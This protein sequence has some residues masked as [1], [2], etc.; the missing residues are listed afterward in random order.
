V[1]R[2]IYITLQ[3]STTTSKT[4]NQGKGNEL[5]HCH[6]TLLIKKKKL[7]N[8]DID[9]IQMKVADQSINECS[10]NEMR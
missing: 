7:R 9:I 8:S 4:R 2:V 3:L 6:K 5:F 1:F 10:N